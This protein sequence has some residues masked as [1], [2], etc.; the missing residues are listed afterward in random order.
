MEQLINDIKEWL[1]NYPIIYYNLKFIGVFALAFAAYLF[2][3]L[4]I[5]KG[6]RRVVRKTKT[7]YDDIFLND[8]LLRRISYIPPIYVLNR[9]AY[10]VPDLESLIYLLTEI[11]IVVVILLI[12]SSA[13]TSLNDI[14]ER[15]SKTADRPIKGYLQIVKIITFI[16]GGLII[17]G[18]F[19]KQDP[20]TLITG[21]G[22]LTAVII[23]IFRDTILSFVAS[24]Q[25][26][27]YDLVRKGDWIEMPKYGADG[28]VVDISLNVIKVQNWDKTI[29]V[30]PTY[31]LIED[32]FINWRGMQLSGGR[33]IKRPIYID[34]STVKF[35]DDEILERLKKIQLL[36][37][38]L[39]ERT[40]E[41]KKFN[42]EKNIDDSVLVNGRRM[43]NLGTF[44]EYLKR[45]LKNREDV[46]MRLTF[47]VRHLDPGPTGI[48]IEIYVF[49]KTIEWAKY[50]EIQANIFDHIFAVVKEFDLRVFQNPTGSDFGKL[51]ETGANSPD[52]TF[53]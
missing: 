45:Y 7:D 12:I 44:R 3:R 33:R 51:K 19:T 28:D 36:K 48:P 24:V 41:I 20:W 53:R 42:K 8:K 43:T 32:S 35:I 31:K 17:I 11:L 21:I 15:T 37:D 52:S 27:S 39:E 25:I 5:L 50:E 14:Y 2:T 6:L 23:L 29:T 13:I 22:A 10:L 9:F 30:I 34:V 47:L 26:S 1:Q 40:E 46:D 49:A 4:I 38:Y 18:I 16:F